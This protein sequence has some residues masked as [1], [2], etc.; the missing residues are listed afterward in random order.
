[1][2]VPPDRD[3]LIAYPDRTRTRM[4]SLDKE[5]L[6]FPVAGRKRLTRADEAGNLH[7][8]LNALVHADRIFL[9]IGA[10][11]ADGKVQADGPI[12]AAALAHALFQAGKRV[13]IL[14]DPANIRLVRELL[15]ILNPE[16]AEF[17]RYFPVHAVNGVLVQKMSD[18][19]AKH[20]PQVLVHLGVA[21]KNR[22]GLHLD[23]HGAYIGEYNLALDQAM[24]LANA[25]GLS[26]IAAGCALHHAGMAGAKDI[27]MPM[28]EDYSQSRLKASHQVIAGT[29][30]LAGL[31][32]AEA[33]SAAY[34]NTLLCDVEQLKKL[35]KRAADCRDEKEYAVLQARAVK[36][37]P[38]SGHARR[39]ETSKDARSNV[40]CAYM[41]FVEAKGLT[42]IHESIH[43]ERL[44]WT[45]EIEERYLKGSSL[46]YVS[47]VDSSDGALIAAKSFWG[48]V[49][50]RS[51]YE[52]KLLIATDHANAPYGDKT[53]E[54]RKPLVVNLL[55][56][57]S[58]Q[59][60]EV[61]IMMCNTAC[62]ENLEKIK[63]DIEADAR[64]NGRQTAVHIIDLIETTARA[65]VERGDSRPVL[66][67]TEGTAKSGKYPE[68]IER[69]AISRG[70]EIPEY[71]VI[72]AGDKNNPNLKDMDWPT[73]V[74]HEYHNKQ[75]PAT[76]A[77]LETEINRYVDQIPLNATSIVLACTHFPAIKH[78]IAERMTQRLREAGYKHDIPIIDP[79]G[80]QADATIAWLDA[81]P[82]ATKPE[83]AGLPRYEVRTSG[84][85]VDIAERVKRL[86]GADVVVTRAR[87]DMPDA[88]TARNA[89][90][91]SKTGTASRSSAEQK[92]SG[93]AG[94]PQQS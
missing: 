85:P 15:N 57:T 26:T 18:L 1:M 59:G 13:A 56:Y 31:A 28:Q 29:A 30:N 45:N 39:Q 64:K 11:T 50:T 91:G 19:I 12:G 86:L 34:T 69:E 73:L 89:H 90:K 84:H 32:L 63:T 92:V 42:L 16:C 46:R 5:L 54:A 48:Y 36:D 72:A 17:F 14:G 70:M 37:A 58:R 93:T 77:Q 88:A 53:P 8:A 41:Q 75:A 82:I 81:H 78:L 61:I 2:P 66:L 33:L 47:I 38:T 49:R 9:V 94:E 71:L 3:A 67:S 22:D 44:P 21:G 60:T 25:F 87:Y 40:D 62:V 51:D 43:S 52:L 10:N 24:E 35:N 55:T 7:T 74:N 20:G 4:K 23:E 65:I 80:D 68:A 6:D 76:R 79:V 83:Y 27:G